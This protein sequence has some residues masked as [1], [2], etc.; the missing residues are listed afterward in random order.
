[1]RLSPLARCS[2]ATPT[3]FATSP[4]D[5]TGSMMPGSTGC[6]D[7]SRS[8][9]STTIQTVTPSSTAPL[10]SAAR[11]T[12]G[13]QPEVPHASAGRVAIQAPKSDWPSGAASVT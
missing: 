2:S 9:A 6:G 1:L 8:T 13:Y 5:A 12:T 10:T 7:W 11:I 3:R 4:A